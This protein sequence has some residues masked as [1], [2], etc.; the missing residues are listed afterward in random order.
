MMKRLGQSA[1]GV[2]VLLMRK[3]DNSTIRFGRNSSCDFPAGWY[4]YAG[5]AMGGLA[6]RLRHHCGISSR[7][8]WHI[9]RLRHHVTLTGIVCGITD[10]R[11]E[12]E[13]S[14]NLSRILDPVEGFGASDCGCRSH[15]FYHIT[16]KIVEDAVF[17]AFEDTGTSAFMI[18]CRDIIRSQKK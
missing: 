8:H 10:S 3:N 12:C 15:L 6:G 5:S 16:K 17:G 1:K 14:H 9:D 4:G 11:I 18:Q 13:I 7:P 2:Y